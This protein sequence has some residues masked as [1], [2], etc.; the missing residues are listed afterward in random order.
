MM[1]K[2]LSF[3]FRQTLPILFGYIFLGIA[4]GISLQQAGFGWPWALGISL[5]LYA[6][7][8][9]FVLVS[10]LSS[11]ASLLT[12]GMVSL[13]LNSRQLFYGLSFLS[14]F[15][16]MGAKYPYMVCSLTDETYSLLCTC[17]YPPD[18]NSQTADFLISLL[19]HF[20]WVAGSV[21]GSLAGQWLPLDFT[22]IDFSM[23]ALFV[24]LFLEQCKAQKQLLP[25]LLGLSCGLFCLL[26]TGASNFMIPALCSCTAMLFLFRSRIEPSGEGK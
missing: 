7:S 24:V 15:R 1:K 25:A 5:L 3:S 4:F 22:G 10:L 18:I 11:G 21:L 12:A 26:L 2:I 8:M 13:V 6:G 9:Q 16:K 17:N 14:R 19:N 20:Y 23:T